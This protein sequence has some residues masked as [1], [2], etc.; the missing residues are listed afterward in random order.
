MEGGLARAA[1]AGAAPG[2]RLAGAGAGWR[3]GEGAYAGPGGEVV[4]ARVGEIVAVAAAG[5]GAGAGAGGGGVVGVARA[6]PAPRVPAPGDVVLARV[7]RVAP[8]AAFCEIV[9]AAGAPVAGAFPAQIRQQDVRAAETD[10]V[11]VYDCFRPG[12][13]V[14][15]EVLSLGDARAYFLSTAGAGLGVVYARHGVSGQ[16]MVPRSWEEME[17]PASGAREP[18][19]V[20][21]L[22]G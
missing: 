5:G 3:A 12:D 7:G 8:R 14:R 6:G 13:V 20:A 11:R 17:C 18:R 21:K 16:P 15:A 1:G 22:D 10:R 2:Q 9:C 4:A 19:K